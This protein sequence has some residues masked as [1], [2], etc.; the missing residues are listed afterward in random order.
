IPD[1]VRLQLTLRA[2]REDVRDQLIDGI[3]RRASGL[4]RAH[5]ATKPTVEVIESIPPTVNTPKLVARVVPA[6][7][8]AL[9]DSNVKEVDP[10]MG[11][12]D[13][14]LFGRGGVS[15]FL[16]R[17]GTIPPERMAEAKSKG[18]T[19]PSLHS[20]K[21]HPDPAPSL[22]TGIRAMTAAVCGLLPVKSNSKH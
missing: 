5:R 14:G 11:A 17:L 1:E 9:G 15:T 6:L 19:L 2:Y 20:S 3:K 22:R 21:Y 7:A 4:A 16:F 12:E 8:K 13:F 18:E 10:V